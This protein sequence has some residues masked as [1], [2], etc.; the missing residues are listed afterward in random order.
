MESP[1]HPSLVSDAIP[2]DFPRPSR[3]SALS[4]AQPKLSLLKVGDRYVDANSSDAQIRAAYVLCEDLAQQ[5]V[6]YCQRKLSESGASRQAI[7]A[8]THA[9]LSNKDW[10][11]PQEVSWTMKRTASLLGWEV[12]DQ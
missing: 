9:G 8:D 10:C 11:S 12:P 3:G 5:L 1:T 7:L 2:E 4:G 6:S